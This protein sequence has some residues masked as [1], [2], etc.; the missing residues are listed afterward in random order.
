[1]LP[2][3]VSPP[4]RLPQPDVDAMADA[5]PP[6][7]P[8]ASSAPASLPAV[9]ELMRT[10]TFRLLRTAS[11]RRA[12]ALGGGGSRS[13]RALGSLVDGE[14]DGGGDGVTEP[15]AAAAAVAPPGP[16]DPRLAALV[17]ELV[18]QVGG[19]QA[20]EHVYDGVAPDAALAAVGM[21]AEAGSDA[22]FA[23]FLAAHAGSHHDDAWPL[24]ARVRRGGARSADSS[25]PP[26]T[27][28]LA[29]K[30][31]FALGGRLAAALLV[32]VGTP[33]Q[34][35]PPGRSPAA[36]VPVGSSSVALPLS[37]HGLLA[38]EA[39]HDALSAGRTTTLA[40]VARDDARATLRG[41]VDQRVAVVH[42]P[43]DLAA[44]LEGVA[45]A[46]FGCLSAG[47]VVAETVEQPSY[48]GTADVSALA[49]E[50]AALLPA[51][52]FVSHPQ[53]TH[54]T[55][56]LAA[57][58]DTVCRTA[59]TPTTR[60]WRPFVVCW[61]ALHNRATRAVLG[62]SPLPGSPDPSFASPS[63]MFGG[64]AFVGTTGT[65]MSPV[66]LGSHFA[67][68]TTS[69]RAREASAASPAAPAS[70]PLRPTS[71]SLSQ[72]LRSG[73]FG[74]LLHAP[75]AAGWP[76]LAAARAAFGDG[77]DPPAV[78]LRTLLQS[79]TL[80]GMDSS[81]RFAPIALLSPTAA[82][83]VEYR[84]FTHVALVAAV[85]AAAA[86]PRHPHCAHHEA[87]TARARRRRRHHGIIRPHGDGHRH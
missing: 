58:R 22:N 49:A 68:H 48:E 11:M 77:G 41:V 23:R 31:L 20:L 32:L 34:D 67:R 9:H 64:D 87:G 26:P 15:G 30:H 85:R 12:G 7:A 13:S 52:V 35:G 3:L 62:M 46:L 1:M 71:P 51:V 82:P 81:P 14:G 72:T 75:P 55:R 44:G 66:N 69:S 61:S 83:G 80:V 24:V 33:A 10:P 54:A 38:H 70:P 53:L 21:R 40:G 59:T 16:P 36:R 28:A 57:A 8:A 63:G 5:P 43:R 86:P 78:S 56:A 50:Y 60:A 39:A 42:T 27:P 6:S 29:Y 47:I 19:A 84:V 4:L 25:P 76:A 17:V 18:C 37:F 2:A 73:Q 74:V 45:V 79:A 65:A